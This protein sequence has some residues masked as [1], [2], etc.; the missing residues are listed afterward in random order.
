MELNIEI[1]SKLLSLIEEAKQNNT[2]ELEARF[3]SKKGKILINEENYNKVFQKL[4][5][6]KEYNGY[7]YEYEMKNMLDVFISD[8]NSIEN[9]YENIRMT[10]NNTDNIKK[11]WL[12]QEFDESNIVF[13]EKEKIDKIDEDNYNIR[14]SLNNELSQDNILEKNK[15]LI[16]SNNFEKVFRLKNRYSIKTDDK[17]FLIDFI[18]G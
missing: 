16:L 5:F 7:G 11:Y 9:N 8:K 3:W 10:I 17:L 1:F 14:F 12:N 4:T 15:N 13:I 6:S 2:Y 18:S